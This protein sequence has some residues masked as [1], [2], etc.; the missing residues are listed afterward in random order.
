MSAWGDHIVATALR[1]FWGEQAVRRWVD[2]NSL[3][4]GQRARRVLIAG[5]G[6][7]R[8]AESKV[9]RT[10]SWSSWIREAWDEKL[11]KLRYEVAVDKGLSEPEQLSFLLNSFIDRGDPNASKLLFARLRDLTEGDL[12]PGTLHVSCCNTFDVIITTNYDTLFERACSEAGLPADVVIVE[13]QLNAD[14]IIRDLIL[15]PGGSQKRAGAKLIIKYH[16]SFAPPG[17]GYEVDYDTFAGGFASYLAR[18]AAMTRTIDKLIGRIESHNRAKQGFLPKLFG[19]NGR[20]SL[21]PT[22]VVLLGHGL[23]FSDMSLSLLIAS[24]E[25]RIS[26]MLDFGGDMLD[27]LRAINDWGVNKRL[28]LPLGVGGGEDYRKRATTAFVSSLGKVPNIAPQAVEFAPFV[29]M[30]GQASYGY[31]FRTD[32][33]IAEHSHSIFG[34]F[35]G[36][37]SKEG[38]ER[39]GKLIERAKIL[40]AEQDGR[41]QL[42]DGWLDEWRSHRHNVEQVQGQ[43]LTPALLMDAWEVQTVFGSI[44]GPD[45]LGRR[46]LKL[47]QENCPFLDSTGVR[48]SM[49]IGRTDHSFVA[50]FGGMRTLFDHSESVEYADNR[51]LNADVKGLFDELKSRLLAPSGSG[52]RPRGVPKAVYL[53]KWLLRQSEDLVQALVKQPQPPLVLYETG[54]VGTKELKEEQDVLGDVCD[55]VLASPIVPMRIAR[56]PLAPSQID[57][58]TAGTTGAFLWPELDERGRFAGDDPPTAT[59]VNQWHELFAAH[60]QNANQLLAYHHVMFPVAISCLGPAFLARCLFEGF[61]GVYD[62]RPFFARASH[63]IVTAGEFGM[64]VV[65][66]PHGNPDDWEKTAKIVWVKPP[67]YDDAKHCIP[68]HKVLNTLG[69]GDIARGAFIGRFMRDDAIGGNREMLISDQNAVLECVKTAVAAGKA[70]TGIFGLQDAIAGMDY[71]RIVEEADSCVTYEIREDNLDEFASVARLIYLN[72]LAMQSS[73]ERDCRKK[74]KAAREGDARNLPSPETMTWEAVRGELD[75]LRKSPGPQDV[76]EILPL[77]RLEE[78]EKKCFGTPLLVSWR[79]IRRAYASLSAR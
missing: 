53:S 45:V 68:G 17:T 52:C 34:S 64:F 56:S 66:R 42:A 78:Y 59:K 26:M 71:R 7:S 40:A 74:D 35:H 38:R 48:T 44:I 14:P 67:G 5:N 16:G 8:L 37:I 12:A 4:P 9:G 49:S 30:I 69:C 62:E 39:S 21:P 31:V 10:V 33:P 46:I 28:S 54:S 43:I 58:G 36:E 55:I 22:D 1:K 73:E 2:D 79:T 19:S 60:Q 23:S 70:R 77:E 20:G 32:R 47:L 24:L 13:G 3:A 51:E 27:E 61:G 29:L 57:K 63:W 6:L 65:S 75:N 76:D 41:R 15:H 50:A 72:F 25:P 11:L 18:N